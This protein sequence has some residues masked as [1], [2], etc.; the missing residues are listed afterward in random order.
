LSRIYEFPTFE[1]YGP[2]SKEWKRTTPPAF[3]FK[4]KEEKQ[5]TEVEEIAKK[6]EERR[7]GDG[8]LWE[9]IKG[10]ETPL[11]ASPYSTSALEKRL[12]ETQT[13]LGNL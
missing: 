11:F 2:E 4:T 1:T 8:Y 13:K 9:T 3:T 6:E 12:A 5:E 7:N 10:A